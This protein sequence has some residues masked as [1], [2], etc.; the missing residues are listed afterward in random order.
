MKLMVIMVPVTL[1]YFLLMLDTSIVS[2]A[3]PTITS[4]FDSLKDIGWY[5]GAYQLASSAFQPLSGKI[6][7]YFST[8]WSFLIFFFVFEVGSAVCGAA[9]SSAMFIIGRAIA[10]LGSSGL[11]NGSLTMVSGILPPHRQ[12][13]VMGINTGLG[14]IGIACGPLVGGAFT[15]YVSWRW[16]FYIN[17]PIG[18][19][20][21][22]LLVL[23][24]IPE[25]T[26]KPPVRQILST[27]IQSLDLQGF[28]LIAP[29]AIMF[30][31]ALQWGGNEYPWDSS[32]IIG[33]FVGAGVTFIVFLFWEHRK[34]DEAMMPFFMIRKRIIWSASGTMFFFMGVLLVAMYYLPIYFQSVK[35]DSAVMSGV[36]ILPT[37][38]SQVI[39][40]MCSGVTI[41]ALGYYLPWVLSG[42]AL[43]AIGQGLL[44]MIS[45][46]TEVKDWVGYQIILG[47][48]CGAAATSSY[49][50]IQNLVPAAQIP[51]A[52]AILI[53][54]QNLGGA[55]LLIV[56]QTVFS[57]SLR[58]QLT[59]LVPDA[60]AALIIAAGARS[61]RQVVSGE[62]LAGVLQAY[63]VSVD[64]VMYLGVATSAA[65]FAF[66]CGLG[67]KDIRV[68]RGRKSR[69]S[70]AAMIV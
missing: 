41:E 59:Q 23:V 18:A 3:V 27:A 10:G 63:S 39:F 25:A 60:D 56:A 4:E 16:C 64:R 7:T 47:V 2:T 35:D 55:V 37:I 43:T 28:C 29:A 54:C 69:S 67:W 51:I 22:L 20:V 5:G 26:P 65:A 66:A 68:E 57:S 11:M 70:E 48:G 46:S 17:L 12:P 61:V 6:Y 58:D 24:R 15:Q 30:F 9:Q 52:M 33:L 49:I 8:K 38:V 45:P 14:Q 40:A 44:S 34:G 36:H 32:T 31:L 62:Q 53:F 1:V 19:A 13:L 50:A 21:G 42:T